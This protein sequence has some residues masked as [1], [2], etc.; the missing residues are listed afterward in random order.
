MKAQEIVNSIRSKLL[1]GLNELGSD[2][3]ERIKSS[4][5][6]PSHPVP[7]AG[8]PPHT[9]SGALLASVGY[10]VRVNGNNGAVLT[11]I[12]S[13]EHA[14]H[15]EFGTEKMAARPFMRPEQMRLNKEVAKVLKKH[16][17][18]NR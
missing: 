13:A 2:S 9:A 8:Q 5:S 11:L 16:L 1:K 4:I 6:D 7:H 3:V 14:E 17:A 15:Q 18:A 12:A 10:K